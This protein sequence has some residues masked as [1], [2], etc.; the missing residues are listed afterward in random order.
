MRRG[1]G[2]AMTTALLACT[3][4]GEL[5]RGTFQYECVLEE[6]AGCGALDETNIA[7]VLRRTRAPEA[8]FASPKVLPSGMA[9][10]NPHVGMGGTAI[11]REFELTVTDPDAVRR[12]IA[13]AR[14]A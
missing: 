12:T 10:R 2:L 14:Q 9:F 1:I 8:H 5:Q 13:A 7:D 3:T 4:E 11:E 6:D